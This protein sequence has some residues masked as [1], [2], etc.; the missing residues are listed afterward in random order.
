M[1]WTPEMQR[2]WEAV[3]PP[4]EPPANCQDC[5]CRHGGCAEFTALN[6]PKMPY[7]RGACHMYKKEAKQDAD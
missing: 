5:E 7:N 1:T 3:R 2:L 4:E 6:R